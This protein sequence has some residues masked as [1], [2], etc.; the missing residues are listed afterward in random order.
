MTK[1]VTVC[2]EFYP[3]RDTGGHGPR[4]VTPNA[5]T[6]NEH[7]LIV[8]CRRVRFNQRSWIRIWWNFNACRSRGEI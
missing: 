8:E 2:T 4:T 7:S 6:D 1:T 5:G 3:R